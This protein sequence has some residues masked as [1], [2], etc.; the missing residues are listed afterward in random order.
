MEQIPSLKTKGLG[1]NLGNLGSLS[2]EQDPE[3]LLKQQFSWEN[4][5][6]TIRPNTVKSKEILEEL[7][8]HSCIAE[9]EILED[10]K[11]KLE[12]SMAKGIKVLESNG[13]GVETD[14][15]VYDSLE[16]FL[17]RVSPLYI[18]AFTSN[19]DFDED[20]AE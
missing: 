10:V 17:M 1:L 13:K 20:V 6:S 9:I 11:Y 18:Q 15:Q 16:G 12:C 4:E 7:D 8:Q 5:F 19:E 3:S 14:G 2:H